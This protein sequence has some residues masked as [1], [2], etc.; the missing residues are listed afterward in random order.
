[1]ARPRLPIA[2]HG[3]INVSQIAPGKW[4]ARTRYRFEDGKLRQVERFAGTKGKAHTALLSALLELETPTRA[5]IRRD[6]MLR[7]LA[8]RFI[9]DRQDKLSA[10][11]IGTY[12]AVIETVIVPGVG[13]LTV[14]EA[15]TERLDRFLRGVSTERGPGLAKTARSVLSGMFGL[16]A[17]NGAVAVNPVREVGTIARKSEGAVAIPIDKMPAVLARVRDD[18]QLAELD[19]ADLIVFLA[20]TGPR[21]GEAVALSWDHVRPGEVDFTR[22]VVRVKDQGLVIQEHTKT[23]AG[24]RTIAVPGFVDEMLRRRAADALHVPGRLV[25]PTVL[26]NVRDPNNTAR[27]WRLHRDRLGAPGSSFHS[28][29]KYVATVLDASGLS[30]REIAE[31]LGHARPSLTQDVYMSRTVGGTR[32]AAGLE[33]VLGTPH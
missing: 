31:Y 11:T 33:K 9:A 30:A 16:A 32:A 18:D 14:R 29:R 20:G 28:F 23:A 8:E 3:Q 6:T 4:R 25:F 7:D 10:G 12:R 27:D 17:R 22:T 21:I 5:P 24:M 2:T 13:D 19:L 1:M 15:T 26:G